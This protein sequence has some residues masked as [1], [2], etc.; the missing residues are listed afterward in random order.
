MKKIHVQMESTPKSTADQIPPFSPSADLRKLVNSLFGEEDMDKVLIENETRRLIEAY[1]KT[2]AFKMVKNP[3]NAIDEPSANVI[4]SADPKD[5]ERAVAQLCGDET[6]TI[7]AMQFSRDLPLHIVHAVLSS[8]GNWKP[9]AMA[10]DPNCG[11]LI[12]C[13]SRKIHGYSIHIVHGFDRNTGK[14]ER[15]VNPVSKFRKFLTEDE[16]V[17]FGDSMA[18]EIFLA[19]WKSVGLEPP[20]EW[21]FYDCEDTEEFGFVHLNCLPN[22][23]S[24]GIKLTN[25]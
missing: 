1:K 15:S 9:R 22:G 10:M 4:M 3:A 24:I 13:L 12:V 21:P 23:D 18:K 25:C 8:I 16:S 20:M 19:A 17:V 2:E 14:C 11:N 5:A 6:G 7:A